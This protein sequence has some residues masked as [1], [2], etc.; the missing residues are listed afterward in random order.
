MSTVMARELSKE[1]K[2]KLKSSEKMKQ[3]FPLNIE[4]TEKGR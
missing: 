2:L 4:L 3:R 1:E